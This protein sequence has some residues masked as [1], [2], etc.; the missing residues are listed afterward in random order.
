MAYAILSADPG[1]EGHPEKVDGIRDQ[2]GQTGQREPDKLAEG[3]E[4]A[5]R[6][7]SAWAPARS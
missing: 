5:L 4:E 1:A 3:E 2:D 7:K 6:V